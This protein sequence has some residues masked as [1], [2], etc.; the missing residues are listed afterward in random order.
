[1]N[2]KEP[3]IKCSCKS[4][5][6]YYPF[7]IPILFMLIR[8]FQDLLF[9]ITKPELSFKILRYNL[10]HLFYL[11][12]PKVFSI[13]LISI[14]KLNTKGE[15]DSEE[16]NIVLRNYHIIARHKN[17]KKFLLLIYIIS[18]LEV[19]CDNGDCLLYYYQRIDYLK[20]EEENRLGWLIEKKSLYIVFVPIL[21]Y[22]IL[23][24]KLYKHH[25]LALILGFIGACI[26]NICRFTLDFSHIQDFPYHLLNAF[27]SLLLSLSLVIIKYIMTKFL[28]PSP[29]NFLFIDGIFCI[30]NS[31]I[32]TLVIYPLVI[33]LPNLNKNLE[34][35]EENEHYFSNNFLQII[36]IFIEQNW[37]FY[38]YFFLII[39][40]LFIY[41]V[42]N[43]YTIYYFSPYIF[44]LLEALLPIDNDFIALLFK[45]LPDKEK[46]IKRTII[47]SI[48]YLILFIASLIMNEIIIFNFFDLNSN[49]FDTISTRGELD[50]SKLTELERY[51]TEVYEDI[52]ND[53]EK[54]NDNNNDNDIDIDKNFNKNENEKSEK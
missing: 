51:N 21:C 31:F 36:T 39:I 34:E 14:I 18:L 12:L 53:N 40:L 6:S 30:F 37:Q 28:I 42:I 8:Y 50:S 15:A 29:Y 25:I 47:Q 7:F 38:I 2:E 49:T 46:I 54:D 41:Y 24:K 20:E 27:F 16:Q 48:G 26:I 43:T 3:C 33:N 32:Y 19:V 11:H 1:M 9:E 5:I 10:P 17:R 35:L 23:D 44:I 13:F 45:T 52:E 4:K 22:F